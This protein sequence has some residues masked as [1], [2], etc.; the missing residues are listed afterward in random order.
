MHGLLRAL[1]FWRFLLRQTALRGA[2]S[3]GGHGCGSHHAMCLHEGR[4]CPSPVCRS[5]CG[6]CMRAGKQGLRATD[7]APLAMWLAVPGSDQ[8]S[9]DGE[10][11]PPVLQVWRPSF[12]QVWTFPEGKGDISRISPC[13]QVPPCPGWRHRGALAQDLFTAVLISGDSKGS[14]FP[15]TPPSA[16]GRPRR[17]WRSRTSSRWCRGWQRGCG[18]R[19]ST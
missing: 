10:C 15:S 19:P 5:V 2:S 8:S 12:L 11:R 7:S 9:V 3:A 4:I 6:I 17:A 13:R 16:G 14:R 1:F 18:S